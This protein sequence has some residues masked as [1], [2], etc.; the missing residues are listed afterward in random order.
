VSATAGNP[1]TINLESIN[2]GTGLARDLPVDA[3]FRDDHLRLQRFRLHDQRL[4]IHE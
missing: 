4:L 2:P 3:P 1:F